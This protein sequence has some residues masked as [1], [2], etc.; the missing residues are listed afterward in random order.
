MK[1]GFTLIE[2]LAVIVIL[3]II[4]LIATPLVLN[5][6]D[7]SKKE[8]FKNTAYGIVEAAELNYFEDVLKNNKNSIVFKYIN[9]VENSNVENK[10]LNYKGNKPQNGEVKINK[11][12]QVG[13]AIHDGKYCAEKSLQSS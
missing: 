6:I 5:V 12:G 3:A 2:L 9:G 1:R 4:A 13:M 7:D 8:A 10:K 11:Y